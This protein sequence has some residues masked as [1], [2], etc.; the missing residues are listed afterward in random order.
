MCTHPKLS[1]RLN[2]FLQ[3]YY[4]VIALGDKW[5]SSESV[6]ASR[7]C[8]LSIAVQ[9]PASV[10]RQQREPE[11]F[12]RRRAA[13]RAESETQTNPNH[14]SLGGRK[15]PPKCESFAAPVSSFPR[16]RRVSSE[17][18]KRPNFFGFLAF[19]K[20]FLASQ[21]FLP[22]APKFGWTRGSRT[23]ARPFERDGG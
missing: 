4:L 10:Y 6:S 7:K 11:E 18:A 13:R 22:L 23:L 5:N 8:M 21:A 2:S 12:R 14:W 17:N 20:N 19:K 15:C 16:H 9:L 3:Y 1:V